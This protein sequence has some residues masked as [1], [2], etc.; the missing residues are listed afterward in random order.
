MKFSTQYNRK[1]HGVKGKKFKLPSMTVPDMT[2]TVLELLQN[3]TRN[4]S[5]DVS[6]LNGEYFETEIP[7]IID[8]LTE[9][10]EIRKKLEEEEKALKERLKAEQKAEQVELPKIKEKLPE[11]AK[12]EPEAK[13]HAS[14]HKETDDA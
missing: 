4:I 14:S 12:K 5:S 6:Q 1:Y 7:T 2:L 11:V 3:H 8:P 10:P 9:L 13:N